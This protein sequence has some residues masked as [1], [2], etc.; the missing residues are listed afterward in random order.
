MTREE[1]FDIMRPIVIDVTGVPECILDDQ[2]YQA[3]SGEYCTIEP[4]SNLKRVGRGTVEDEEVASEDGEDYYDIKE[5]VTTLM[6]ARVSVNFFRG[7]ARD[8]AD[9]LMF[10]DERSDVH[11]TLYTNSL[12]WMRTD[13]VNNLTALNSG[14]YEPRSQINIYIQFEQV[15][16]NTVQQIYQVDFEIENEDGDV[17]TT[18]EYVKDNP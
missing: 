8:Y 3:P 4:Y 14:R 5:T 2:N 12:G 18:G 13:A 10:C 15:Q 16:T 17:I 6:E 11:E 7:S 1:L 9:S